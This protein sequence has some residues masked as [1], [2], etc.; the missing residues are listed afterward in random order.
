MGGSNYLITGSVSERSRS[1]VSFLRG[2]SSWFNN[3]QDRHI[4]EIFLKKAEK[5]D[6]S[7]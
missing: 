6:F 3:P 5:R 7:R 4:A 1:V 2:L